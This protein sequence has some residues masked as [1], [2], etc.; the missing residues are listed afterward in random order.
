MDDT[1]KDLCMCGSGGQ[2]ECMDVSFLDPALVKRGEER[3]KSGEVV[4]NVSSP[5]DCESCSG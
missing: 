5:E 4:C 2:C 1:N 3:R